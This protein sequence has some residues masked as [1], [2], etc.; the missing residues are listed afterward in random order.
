MRSGPGW[1]GGPGRLPRHALVAAL[2]ALAAAAGAPA[3]L[4][5]EAGDA[6][7]PVAAGGATRVVSLNPS[8]T[9]I[10][11]ALGA[12]D[13][14]VGVDDFSAEQQ[15]AVRD[16]PRV[17][18]LYDPN[19]E[20]VLAL[21][22]DLVVLV[23]S[24]QQRDFR[25][26]LQDVGVPV[27][28]LDPERFD[29]VL[30]SIRTLGARVDRSAEARARV[31][32]IREARAGVERRARGRERPRTVLVLQRQP[33]YVV[34]PGSFLD[35]MLRAAGAENV[36]ADLPGP[37]PRAGMEWLVAAAPEV[38]LDASPDATPPAEHWARWPSLPAVQDGRVL[39]VDA[40]RVTLPGPFLD[41]ALRSLAQAIHPDGA[42]TP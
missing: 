19:L 16:L 21:R 37:Y 17:G 12:G 33:L 30:A 7:T 10:L 20:A 9:A 22:P 28:A 5:A 27:L 18:G 15:P 4:D 2:V 26:R 41:R 11:L 3:S 42:A 39:R 13:R 32:A 6:P 1:A 29:E 14:L 38:L 36:A 8:L 31:D 24:A 25:E 34:G 40:P 23:P 35:E